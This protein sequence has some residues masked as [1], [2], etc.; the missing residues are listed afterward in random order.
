MQN[1]IYIKLSLKYV[2]PITFLSNSTPGEFAYIWESKPVEIIAK[3]NGTKKA[4]SLTKKATSSPQY[5]VRLL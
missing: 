5:L 3:K 1:K 2:L 4:D